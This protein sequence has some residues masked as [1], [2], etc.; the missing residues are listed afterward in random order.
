MPAPKDSLFQLSNEEAKDKLTKALPKQTILR[1]CSLGD[2]IEQWSER[3][4]ERLHGLWL[5]GPPSKRDCGLWV[6]ASGAASRMFGF[7]ETKQE[8][9]EL[10]WENVDRLPFGQAWKDKV[11]LRYGSPSVA[12]AK[13]ACDVLIQMMDNGAIPKG[14]VPF[15][16]LDSTD[17]GIHCTETAFQA[18]LRFWQSLMPSGSSLWFTVQ[19]ER[20]EEIR[21]HLRSDCERANMTL[22]LPVQP[23]WTDTPMLDREENLVQTERGDVAKR[24]GGHGSLLPL[25]EEVDVPLLAIRNID[26]APSPLRTEERLNWTR[27]M[28]AAAREWGQERNRWL[29]ELKN[30]TLDVEALKAWLIKSGSGMSPSETVLTLDE[31]EALLRRPMRLVG[32][33]RNEGQPGGG[34]FWLSVSTGLD[35]GRIK[36]QIVESTELTDEERDLLSKSTHF[37][38]VDMICVLEPGQSLLPFVDHS[39]Y[40]TT[41]KTRNGEPVRVLEH[42]GLWNGGMSGWL[43]RLVEIPASCFQPAKS[44]LDLLDRK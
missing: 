8:G 44:V 17:A 14:L 23:R 37:N 42:P 32:V 35:Q 6:P 26:N 36:P 33:V 10:L 34:P 39:R 29:A 31:F 41:I 1:P 25:L 7:L 4:F 11:S 18:H 16:V 28:I 13:E 22:H 40:M 30:S 24:P 20:L 38:P 2:G 27:T 43:T 5:D 19:Q 21:T 12:G 15:H 9:S 3:E